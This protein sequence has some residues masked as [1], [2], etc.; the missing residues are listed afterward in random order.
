[1][2]SLTWAQVLGRRLARGCLLAPARD[3][4]EA[5]AAACGVHAQILSAAELSLSARVEG[6]TLARLRDDLWERRLLV[7]TWA[8]RGTLH[9]L[10]AAELPLWL[11]A[12]RAGREPEEPELVEAIAAALDGGPRTREELAEALGDER[13][14]SPWGTWLGYAAR[15]GKL[16]FGPSRGAAPTFV[17]PDRWIGYGAE[18]PADAALRTALRRYLSAYGPARRQDF[19]TWLGLPP[20]VAKELFD[21]A[22]DE[23]EP[24]DVEGKRAFVLAGDDAGWE[25][26]PGSVR[27][28]PH[29]EAYVVGSRFGREQVIPPHVKERALA[30]G[31]GR[32]EGVIAIPAVLVDGVVSG[33]WK[34]DRRAIT[35]ELLGRVPKTSIRREADRIRRFLDDDLALEYGPAF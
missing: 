6:L 1:M 16:C 20:P 3:P 27:L 12:V 13:L 18:P 24:V 17:R 33:F 2:R 8:Q 25:P 35:V 28:L 7:K 19:T 29:Y 22:A 14:R 4:V 21:A 15:A 11:A 5:A 23:L 31:R 26:A 10:P 30:H 9:L 34:R 32:F